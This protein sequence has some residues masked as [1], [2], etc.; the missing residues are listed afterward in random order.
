MQD[1][2]RAMSAAEEAG[3]TAGGG[4]VRGLIAQALYNSA[5]LMDTPSHAYPDCEELY[6]VEPKPERSVRARD[7]RLFTVTDVFRVSP[8]STLLR[9][10]RIW[11]FVLRTF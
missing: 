6:V 10:P 1:I 3:D 9:D 5:S 2:E 4:R 8:R 7:N 11:D